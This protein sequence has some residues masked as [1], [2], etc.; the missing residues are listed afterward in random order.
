MLTGLR[1]RAFARLRSE[2]GFTLAELSVAMATGIVVTIGL[3]WMVVGTVQQSQRTFTRV[4]A[5]RQARTAIANVENELHS[6]CVTGDPPIQAGSD[7]NNLSFLS[8]FGTGANPQPVWHQ[9]SLTSGT[10]TDTTYGATYNATGTGADWTRTGTGVKTTLLTNVAAL[11]TTPVFQ[12]YAYQQQSYTDS[13]GNVYWMIPDGTNIPPG[14]PTVPAAP[15]IASAVPLSVGDADNVVEVVINVLVG[16]S[17][18]N[19]NGPTTH[20]VDDPVTDTISL[21][22]TTPPNYTPAGTPATGYGPCE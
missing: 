4:D 6:A 15:N 20:A 14:P 12:Y 21:R 2:D 18:S 22:L 1:R 11:G 13:A 3:L 16:S 10:L 19:L 8:Y 5:T 17:G 9:I 7:G